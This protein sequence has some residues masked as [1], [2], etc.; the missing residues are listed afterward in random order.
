MLQISPGR[1]GKM[2][3]PHSRRQLKEFFRPL[4]LAGLD[5]FTFPGKFVIVFEGCEISEKVTWGA[6][7]SGLWSSTQND[8]VKERGDDW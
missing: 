6:G 8:T 2:A 5:G 1:Q 4:P 7:T 3:W